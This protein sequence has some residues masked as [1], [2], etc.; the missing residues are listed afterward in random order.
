M[1][2]NIYFGADINRP[3]RAAIHR[4]GRAELLPGRANHDL[5]EVLKRTDTHFAAGCSWMRSCNA[6]DDRLAG[7]SALA[8][9]AVATDQIGG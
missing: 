2:R 8:S 4:K 1:T 6:P 5:T 3:I 9:W 7:G